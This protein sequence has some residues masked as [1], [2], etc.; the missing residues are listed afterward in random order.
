MN[1]N[2]RNQILIP[3]VAATVVGIAIATYFNIQ[4]LI[5][6]ENERLEQKVDD[7]FD[8]MS[9]TSFPLYESVLVQIHQISGFHL[10]VEQDG[11]THSSFSSEEP[12]SLQNVMTDIQKR[13]AT[14]VKILDE[15]FLIFERS[16]PARQLSI[17]VLYPR[18]QISRAISKVIY[19]QLISGIITVIAVVLIVFAVARNVTRPIHSLKNHVGRIAEGHFEQEFNNRTDEVGELFQSI[20]EMASKLQVYEQRIRAQEKL[21]TLD[22]MGGGIAHQMR[23][24]ITGCRLALDFHRQSCHGDSESLDVANRQLIFMED[25]QKRFLSYSKESSREKKNLDLGNVVSEYTKLLE[26]FAKH[27]QVQ[28]DVSIPAVQ[29]LILG[30]ESMLHQLIG[31]LVT[32]AIEAASTYPESESKWVSVKIHNTTSEIVLAIS[33][34]G[35]GIGADVAENIFDPLFT[36]KADGVGL[37][38][39]IVKQTADEH[40]ATI[41]WNRN[42]N[43]TTFE[44][45]F[46][47]SSE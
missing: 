3:I 35:S 28:L 31:N 2:I 8:T 1:W 43:Q 12:V 44:V 11:Q 34:S 18:E 33:D 47:K 37:G 15:H 22:Q 19:P 24:S 17:Y 4:G 46:P 9:A 26:P 16:L 45:R 14:E 13:S 20:N 42:D 38:L 21:F 30:N 23:N 39:A 29:L 36:T 5:Q 10:L 27:L 6:N 25:F 41:E 32:N 40:E 7:L